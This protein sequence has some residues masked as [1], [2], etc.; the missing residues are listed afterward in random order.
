MKQKFAPG[1]WKRS[2]CKGLS[3]AVA[4]TM[5]P[6]VGV[7]AAPKEGEGQPE[8]AGSVEATESMTTREQPFTVKTGS[9]NFSSPAFVVRQIVEGERASGTTVRPVRPT[10]PDTGVTG[11]QQSDLLIAAAEMKYDTT[12]DGGGQDIIT[13]RKSVV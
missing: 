1:F 12:A 11:A 9:A 8:A 13:D 3:L 5:I 7:Q 10:D 4:V 6:S 2:L